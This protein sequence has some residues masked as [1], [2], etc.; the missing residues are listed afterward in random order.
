M[1]ASI[2]VVEEAAR[3][4]ADMVERLRALGCP[5]VEV[6]TGGGLGVRFREEDTGLNVDL[7]AAALARQLGGRNL[8]VATEPGEYI[9]KQVGTLLAEVVT[10]EDRGGG[11]LFAGVDAGWNI[12]NEAFVYSIPYTPILCRAADTAPTHRYTITGHINEGNDIF[13]VD[14]AL[15]ELHEGDVLAIPNVGSYN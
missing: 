5:I 7:W 2:P 3:R 14:A 4:A 8:V 15:P 12:A 13:A 11:A 10:V 6:N 1:T 9:A